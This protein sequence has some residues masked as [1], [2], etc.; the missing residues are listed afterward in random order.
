MDGGF[1]LPALVQPLWGPAPA[2]S[3][4][5]TRA[6]LTPPCQLPSDA[7][8]V[9]THPGAWEF[10]HGKR[11]LGPRGS[12]LDARPPLK[13][14]SPFPP[15]PL[16]HLSGTAPLRSWATVFGPRFTVAH[17]RTGGQVA[18]A[19][20]ARFGGGGELRVHPDGFS[21]PLHFWLHRQARARGEKAR[22]RNPTHVVATSR[23]NR[24]SS[25][26]LSSLFE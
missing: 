15:S 21:L 20:C 11:H 25:G 8:L 22:A 6:F 9:Q 19:I 1:A 10:C 18:V 24:F 17:D 23:V 26:L 13:N 3:G 7:Q 4:V 5:A 12:C 2:C 16:V 14:G